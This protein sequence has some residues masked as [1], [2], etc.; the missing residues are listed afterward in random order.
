[1]STRTISTLEELKAFRD[2][3]NAGNTFK[4]ET[5]EL[6]NDIDLGGEEWTPIGTQSH[7]FQGIFNGNGHTISNLKINSSNSENSGF[8]GFT[9]NGEIKNLTFNNADVVGYLNVGVVAGCPYTSKYSNIKLTGDI[10]VSG[11]AYVG[12]MFGKN[13]YADLTDLTIDAN[14][15][16]YVKADS[17]KYRTYVGGIVGFM[18]EG[19]QTVM[20]VIS[21]ISVIGSTCDIGGIAG[22]AHYGNKFINVVCAAELIQL[23][24]ANDDGDHLEIG[25]IAGVWLNQSGETVL[26]LNC[27]A[28]NTTV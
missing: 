16:S 15:G 20:N 13:A 22:I 10:K 18:G 25:G 9:T 24:N 7:Q 1:M 26:L 4:G 8:F 6:A 5:I 21:N 27:S 17:Q 11:Y 28:E 3:V 12:G 14:A 19:N 2:E 23:V